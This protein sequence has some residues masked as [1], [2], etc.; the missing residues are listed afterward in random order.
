MKSPS[1]SSFSM[2]PPQ[3]ATRK[4]CAYI[5]FFVVFLLFYSIDS[6]HIFFLVLFLV[7]I[8]F[9][10]Q[11][12]PGPRKVIDFS[13]ALN[14]TE[15]QKQK[16]QK[17]AAKNTS[18]SPGEQK[19]NSRPQKG[20]FL[21]RRSLCSAFFL[22][23]KVKTQKESKLEK[24]IQRPRESKAMSSLRRRSRSCPAEP[25]PSALGPRSGQSQKAK[26]NLQNAWWRAIFI[27]FQF[28]SRQ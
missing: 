15:L 23:W 21:R 17:K 13:L 22:L 4:M 28:H 25:L 5:Y 7:H 1:S 2:S 6:W 11:L 20:S 9:H 27:I 14:W 10:D 3:V 8:L 12:I 24:S 26:R 18:P 19:Q 16:E